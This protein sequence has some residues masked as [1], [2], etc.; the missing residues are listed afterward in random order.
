VP[1]LSTESD[2]GEIAVPA[3]VARGVAD[4]VREAGTE[5]ESVL[6]YLHPFSVCGLVVVMS[7]QVSDLPALL[8]RIHRVLPPRLSLHCLRRREL[9]H[10]ALP[11]VSHQPLLDEQPHLAWCAKWRSALLHCRDGRDCRPE[12]PLPADPGLFLRARLRGCRN[13]FRIHVVLGL[14]W[15]RD[16]RDYRRLVQAL[17]DEGRN[18][19]SIALVGAGGW[20]LDL[21]EVPARFAEIHGDDEAWRRLE[22]LAARTRS[23]SADLREDALDACWHFE[24]LLRR[25]EEQCP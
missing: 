4:L 22:E 10:L 20:R 23:A 1:D 18:L 9:F 24:Q 12:I 11:G 19:L 13:H 15:K 21:S 17:A 25:L 2:I 16:P 5:L 7:D 8:A 6:Y 3:P 14:L